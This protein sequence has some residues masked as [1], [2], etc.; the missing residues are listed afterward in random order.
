MR[1]PFG[2]EKTTALELESLGVRGTRPLKGGVAFF[3][4]LKQAYKACLWLRSASR[5]LLVLDRCSAKDAVALYDG[6]K[7]INWQLH[8]NPALTFA[9]RARGINSELKNTQFTALKVK[10]ALCDHLMGRFGA[11]PSVRQNRPDVQ[12]EVAVR[13]NKASLYL[14]L[15]GEPLHRRGYRTQGIQS[16]APLKE[17]LAAG[18]LLKSGWAASLTPLKQ[19]ADRCSNGQ[20]QE[21]QAR[22]KENGW[23]KTREILLDPLCGSG[24]LL[25]EAAMIAAD[26]APGLLREYWGFFGWLGHQ[27][28]TWSQLLAE[29]RMRLE[30]GKAHMPLL[31]GLDTDKSVLSLA[32]EQ[33]KKAGF[34]GC[35]SLHHA[36]V[37]DARQVVEAVL[38]SSKGGAIPIR[39][40]VVSNPPYAERMLSESDLPLLYGKIRQGLE[41]LPA[42]WTAHLITSDATIDMHLGASPY[43]TELLYNGKIEASLRHYR[44]SDLGAT[45]IQINRAPDGVLVSVPVLDKSSEQFAARLKKVAKERKKWAKR[46]GVSCYRVYD[47]DLPDYAFAID[48]Y[49]GVRGSIHEEYVCVAEYKA[50]KEIDPEKAQRRCFDAMTIVPVVMGLE[51]DKLVSKLRER[52]KGGGQYRAPGEA[53]NTPMVVEEQGL[54]FEVDLSGYLD[55]G[56][57]LDHR[58]TRALIRQTAQG[59]DFLNLFAYTGTASVYAAAGGAKS[60]TTVDL[61]NTY[62]SWAKKNMQLNGFT[63]NEHQMVR[64]D[65]LAWLGQEVGRVKGRS[66]SSNKVEGKG[67]GRGKGEGA[68]VNASKNKGEGKDTGEGARYDLIFVDPPTFSNSKKMNAASWSVQRDHVELLK[69]VVLLL[70]PQGKV[71]FSCNLRSFKPNS[72]ELAACGIAIEDITEK[73]IPEDFKRSKRIHRCYL[74]SQL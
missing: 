23:G 1:C 31:I 21:R 18:I 71:L 39:G 22:Q 29:A 54:S 52:A 11:R 49:K 41:K 62:L 26:M 53:V 55:T 61:S 33:A 59:K 50:P 47:A 40:M 13:L 2:L 68:S 63:G 10:D 45:A 56:L 70:R 57:F 69:D 74:V 5:V 72:K 16:E 24:T 37:E 17:N 32:L 7:A 27:E 65:V 42:E 19:R 48:T 46:E 34:E 66:A 67:Q 73:T 20:S 60:T 38:A 44:L 35:M 30:K 15:S 43:E 25:H 4:T 51:A 64:A 3:G 12:L 6:V 14:D 58:L 9:V 8:L 28:E 36:S